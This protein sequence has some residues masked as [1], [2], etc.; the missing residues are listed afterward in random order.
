MSTLVTVING[1][2]TRKTRPGWAMEFAAWVE[3]HFGASASYQHYYASAFAPATH[4]I[5]NRKQARHLEKR[6]LT[7]MDHLRRKHVI[8]AHSNGTNIAVSLMQRLAKQG[9]NTDCAILLGSALDHRI[10]RNGLLGLVNSGDLRRVYAYCSPND[11]VTRAAGIIPGF[12]GELGNRGF[13]AGKVRIG[14]RLHGFEDFER[15]TFPPRLVTRMFPGFGHGEYFNPQFTE[16]TFETIA[17]D[18]EL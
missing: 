15:H 1:I 10:E 2:R 6:T 17:K 16:I 3:R 4:W 18:A 12:W 14:L 8:V 13:H 5:T 9:V 11:R 7:A